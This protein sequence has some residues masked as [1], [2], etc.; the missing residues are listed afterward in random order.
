DWLAVQKAVVLSPAPGIVDAALL[1]ARATGMSGEGTL[2][3]VTFRALRDGDPAL[4]ITS[5]RAR[6][7]ANRPLA[8]D[9]LTWTTDGSLPS[10]TE[11]LAPS[12][13]PSA[14]SATLAFGLAR[15]GEIELALYSVHGRPPPHSL[16]RR[17]RPRSRARPGPLLRAARRARRAAPHAHHRSTPVT[18]MRTP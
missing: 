6:D 10:R 11:L 15:G 13:N 4:R 5:V 8:A 17:R 2:A 18:I 16:A 3:T 9:A 14:A 12:P 7:A 1:G